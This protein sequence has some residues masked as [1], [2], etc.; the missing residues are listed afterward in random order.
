[1]RV[2]VL[3]EAIHVC[4]SPKSETFEIEKLTGDVI[5]AK[6]VTKIRIRE[7]L[8]CS[9]L[10]VGKFGV[11]KRKVEEG[12]LQPSLIILVP[13]FSE[14]SSTLEIKNQQS[15]KISRLN[16]HGF[17]LRCYAEEKRPSTLKEVGFA[18]PA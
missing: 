6:T 2:Y 11:L 5:S 17:S 8:Q 12:L 16:K 3:M 13:G 10:K 1:M 7:L 9:A 4:N 14:D 18:F 15:A